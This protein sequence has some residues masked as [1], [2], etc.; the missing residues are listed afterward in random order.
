MPGSPTNSRDRRLH[1]PHCLRAFT[2]RMGLFGHL[3][4]PF[5]PAILTA[6]ATLT[7]KNDIAPASTDFSFP[8]LRPQ[9]Q[10]THQPS[11]SPANPSQGGW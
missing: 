8:T 5:A 6:T 1:C 3:C 2:H 10:L 7:T 9:L 4:T 11:R